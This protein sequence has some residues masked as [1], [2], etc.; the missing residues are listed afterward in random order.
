MTKFKIKLKYYKILFLIIFINI[1]LICSAQTDGYIA[2]KE[3]IIDSITV[4]GLKSY[5]DQ[6]VISYSGLKIGQKLFLP[7][8]ETG[9]VLKKLWSLDLFS[10]IN[11]YATKI[12]GDIGTW[13]GLIAVVFA[14]INCVGGFMVTDRML[15][16]FKR[17]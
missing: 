13:L 15:K 2:G 3:Y 14:T 4:K 17:K 7:G 11:F 5:N 8:E 16:M 12:D 1:N 10:D 6:T 9:I